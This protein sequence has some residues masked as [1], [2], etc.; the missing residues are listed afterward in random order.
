MDGAG[1]A[2]IQRGGPDGRAGLGAAR[3]TRYLTTKELA[4]TLRI[5]ERK[6]YD[7]AAKGEVP[8][9]RV[10]GKLLFPEDEIRAWIAS[11]RSGP[12]VADPPPILAGSHD[13]LVDWAL[14]E[15]RCGLA[16]LTDGSMDGL[17][18]L[19]RREASAA[20]VHVREP[21]GWNVRAV[22]EAL[23]EAPVVLV[24]IAE[25]RRGLL[26]ARGNPLGLRSVSDLAGR[27]VAR[28]QAGAA[29]EAL[30]AEMLGGA[31][32]EGPVART[33]AELAR[34]VAT[35]AAEAALGL[36]AAAREAGCG[37]VPLLTERLDLACWRRMYLEPPLQRLMRFLAGPEARRRAGEMGG[38]DLGGLGTVRFNGP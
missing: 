6:V 31:A 9:A 21:E 28:R 23:G 8:C 36:E 32:T 20:L 1:R 11:G 38:Y 26:V 17:A 34:L 5:G 15:S 10:V 16:A 13:P 7:L 27:R 18:R 22:R 30:L 35:G 12:T 25:R 19:A 37:F 2:A 4:E 14:L 24:Q 29:S 33:E 3:L